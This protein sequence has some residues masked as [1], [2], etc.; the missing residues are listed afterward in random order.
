MTDFSP[1]WDLVRRRFREAQTLLPGIESGSLAEYENCLDHNELELALDELIF[2]GDDRD[3]P[4]TYWSLL[5]EAAEA[6]GLSRHAAR[7][8]SFAERADHER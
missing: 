7:I 4:V 1:I 8:R 3:V 2:L 5:L 6:M